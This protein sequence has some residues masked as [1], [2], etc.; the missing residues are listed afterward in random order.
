MK[1]RLLCLQL[2]FC[3]VTLGQKDLASNGF[4]FLS[5]TQI[6]SD[7]DSLSN[8]ILDV[9]PAPFAHCSEQDWTERLA[10]NKALPSSDRAEM[11][12]MD[13][14]TDPGITELVQS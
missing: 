11:P 5:G 3:A 14:T 4:T 10:K 2:L 6:Q 7:L 13:S 12:P 8:W 1:I 9:H